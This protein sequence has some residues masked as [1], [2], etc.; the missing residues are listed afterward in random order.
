MDDSPATV[1]AVEVMTRL[2]AAREPAVTAAI[3]MHTVGRVCTLVR[4][5][6]RRAGVAPRDLED[7][8]IAVSELATNVIRHAGGSGSITLRSMSVGLFAEIRDSGPGLP[9]SM[10]IE[11]PSPAVGHGQ[12]LWLARLLCKDFQIV[13]S[14]GGVTVRIFTP[15]ELTT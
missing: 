2:T 1:A 6:G 13:S 14:P 11:R 9:E 5:T 4:A 7:L 15:R 8:L 12:G 3:T 10:T